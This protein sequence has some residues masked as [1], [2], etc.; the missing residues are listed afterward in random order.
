M[1]KAATGHRQKNRDQPDQEN[2]R[3]HNLDYVSQPRKGLREG[4]H[5]DDPPSN[6][7][8]QAND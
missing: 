7:E 8:D 3:K 4:D 1:P 6:R 2:E 5:A